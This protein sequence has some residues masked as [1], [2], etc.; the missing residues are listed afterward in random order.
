MKTFIWFISV[1]LILSLIVFGYHL[2]NAQFNERVIRNL[3]TKAEINPITNVIY[4]NEDVNSDVLLAT[5]CHRK[6]N[7]YAR[8]TFD[9]YAMLIPY[10]LTFETKDHYLKWKDKLKVK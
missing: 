9:I 1:L 6:F 2:K 8:E 3:F 5:I 10:M 4:I 7:L